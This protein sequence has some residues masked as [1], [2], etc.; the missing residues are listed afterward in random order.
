MAGLAVAAA[1]ASQ[2]THMLVMH[3]TDVHFD[4]NYSASGELPL[5]ALRCAVVSALCVCV[6]VSV[7]VCVCVCVCE[8]VCVCVSV[9]VC[10][11]VCVC[12]CVCVRVR[13]SMCG[14]WMR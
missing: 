2:S 14:R 5:R 11:F 7:C 3:V 12:A 13:V 8:C 9:C 10:L 6:C 1:A 4:L